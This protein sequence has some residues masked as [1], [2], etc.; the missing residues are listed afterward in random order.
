MT[1]VCPSC[2]RPHGEDERFC[3][4]CGV[5]LVVEGGPAELA[6]DEIENL[7]ATVWW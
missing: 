5:P 3:S 2:G 6:V 1:L 4:A 7:D